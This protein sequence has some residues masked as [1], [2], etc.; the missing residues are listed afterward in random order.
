M[1]AVLATALPIES[2]AATRSDHAVAMP[3]RPRRFVRR[4]VRDPES[5]RLV[6]VWDA[7]A[8]PRPPTLHLKL[9]RT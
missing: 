1:A 9:V 7:D 6:C 2:F 8:E 3:I 5:G 4:W